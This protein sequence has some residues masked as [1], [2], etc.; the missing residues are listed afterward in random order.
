[1]AKLET[2]RGPNTPFLGVE[3]R[4]GKQGNRK[5]VPSLGILAP[6]SPTT[7][8]RHSAGKRRERERGEKRER[9]ERREREREREGERGGERGERERGREERKGARERRERERERLLEK[10]Q[11]GFA[12]LGAR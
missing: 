4:K 6:S 7:G 1:L 8:N 10:P 11:E 12:L 9:E 3:A 2:L 5:E